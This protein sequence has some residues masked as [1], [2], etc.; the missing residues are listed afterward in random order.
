MNLAE[1]LARF[2]AALP[3]EERSSLVAE[4]P[5]KPSAARASLVRAVRQLLARSF[6]GVG[7]LL[8]AASDLLPLAKLIAAGKAGSLES[9]NRIKQLL[10]PACHKAESASDF[11]LAVLLDV[12][13]GVHESV[14]DKLLPALMPCDVQ[15]TTAA[16][17]DGCNLALSGLHETA[18][19]LLREGVQVAH[20]ARQLAESS[21]RF[22]AALPD[23]ERSS[24]VAEVP[25]RVRRIGHCCSS[26][27]VFFP[28]ERILDQTL[29]FFISWL[30]S[31]L[32]AAAH[33]QFAV[34]RHGRGERQLP[35][36]QQGVLPALL[37]R[38]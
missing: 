21:A 4:V 15:L 6:A 32:G 26:A 13:R 33:Q 12:A 8:P 35:R 34:E 36:D 16:Q 27:G 11:T 23:E 28:V 29:F 19:T 25:P 31:R 14:Q 2:L 17:L 7:A 5:L 3:D 1:S 20:E 30:H 38:L 18:Y 22:L 24:L 9:D 37:Q 10:Q